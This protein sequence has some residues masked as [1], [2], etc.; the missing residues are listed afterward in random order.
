MVIAMRKPIACPIVVLWCGLLLW[1]CGS[2]A[3]SDRHQSHGPSARPVSSQGRLQAV[4][5]SGCVELS[6]TNSGGYVLQRVH[7][8]VQ[9]GQDPQRT[10]AY[11]PTGIV[12]GS[13]V[14][15]TGGRDLPALTGRRVL[16][17]G[18]IVDTGRNAV[19]TTSV[20]GVVLP[21]GDVSPAAKGATDSTESESLTAGPAPEIKVTDIE[22][23][24]ETCSQR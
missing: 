16:V 9:E 19:G 2:S 5:L 24:G 6:G 22:D 21:R 18:V 1:G 15:L 3:D 23:L 17:S 8:E 4:R 12:E 7:V 10:S 13:W 11:A 20:S 14:R